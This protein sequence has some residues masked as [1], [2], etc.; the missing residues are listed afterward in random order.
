MTEGFRSWAPGW[1]SSGLA[2]LLDEEAETQL[3]AASSD[4]PTIRQSLVLKSCITSMAQAAALANVEADLEVLDRGLAKATLVFNELLTILD[5]PDRADHFEG[6]LLEKMKKCFEERGW[7]GPTADPSVEELVK[8][9]LKAAKELSEGSF[10]LS[11]ET[12]IELEDKANKCFSSI[13][14]FSQRT[15]FTRFIIFAFLFR[16]CYSKEVGFT[17]ISMLPSVQREGIHVFL[18]ARVKSLFDAVK[19]KSTFFSS[20]I[21]NKHQESMDELLRVLYPLYSISRGWTN[22]HL[23]VRDLGQEEHIELQI[24]PELLPSSEERPV[25]LQLGR[26]LVNEED[27]A[28][29]FCFL[30]RDEKNLFLRRQEKLFRFVVTHGGP[31]S[32]LQIQLARDRIKSKNTLHPTHVSSDLP[33]KL[34]SMER[35]MKDIESQLPSLAVYKEMAVL[36]EVQL[37]ALGLQI[38]HK[39]S[40]G[41]TLLHLAVHHGKV[42]IVA[43]LLEAGAHRHVQDNA[44]LHPLVVAIIEASALESEETA[45]RLVRLLAS[46]DDRLD[47]PDSVG[48]TALHHASAL[49]SSSLRAK[50]VT[51]LVEAGAPLAST[52]AQGDRPVDV[53]YR[54][55]ETTLFD[56]GN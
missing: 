46:D 2:V 48:R 32:I 29:V 52:D 41:Q 12:V 54:L 3:K 14:H 53:A 15:I 7:T 22:P 37:Q 1:S 25:L 40:L 10:D 23:L 31:N 42:E 21:K 17:P 45:E 49:S 44:G 13:K 27:L 56:A 39:N 43:A 50:L 33:K 51:A 24:N 16:A 8:L 30:W 18:R 4:N 36:G 34:L 20:S 9:L 26:A 11:V 19:R 35:L 5:I 38:N 28:P 47:L 6:R 55:T